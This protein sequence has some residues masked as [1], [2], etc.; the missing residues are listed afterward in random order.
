[1]ERMW[2]KPA[3]VADFNKNPTPTKNKFREKS[4]NKTG[5]HAAIPILEPAAPIG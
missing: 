2:W 3:T 4:E 1:M 5:S